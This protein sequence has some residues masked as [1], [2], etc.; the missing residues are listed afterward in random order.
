MYKVSSAEACDVIASS[1][2]NCRGGEVTIQHSSTTS[3]TQPH[4]LEDTTT[5]NNSMH[6]TLQNHCRH[7]DLHQTRFVD[8]GSF[9]HTQ[10]LE[11]NS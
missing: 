1:R 8:L 10:L 4:K 6:C 11:H 2:V 5:V 3:E 7:L 9:T